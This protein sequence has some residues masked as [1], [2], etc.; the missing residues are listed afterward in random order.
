MNIK[1]RRNGRVLLNYWYN[2]ST[3][4][5]RELGKTWYNEAKEYVNTLSEKFNIQPIIC[6]GVVSALSPNN[7][8]ERNKIDAHAVLEATVYNISPD[9][10]KVCTYNHNKD[11][12]FSIAKGNREILERSP[13]TYAFAHN[14][15]GLD[16]NKVTID[17]WHLRAIQT[18]SKSPKYCKTTITPLQYKLLEKD[19]QRVAGKY[20]LIPSELQAIV[21]VTI[22]NRWTST[23]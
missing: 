23:K 6:A 16:T 19:C 15:S 14:I 9:A 3:T 10:V 1:Q 20:S 2:E 8:W 12:A 22:R 7:R 4:E 5:E 11:K 17:K 18:R 13:K 21:W